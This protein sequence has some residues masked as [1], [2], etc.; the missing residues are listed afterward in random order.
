MTRHGTFWIGWTTTDDGT[1]RNIFTAIPG[2]TSMGTA[3]GVDFTR[4]NVT[5]NGTLSA[6]LNPDSEDDETSFAHRPDKLGMHGWFDGAADSRHTFNEFVADFR[7]VCSIDSHKGSVVTD[8][9]QK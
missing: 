2:G 5:G 7:F 4:T 1:E 3:G 9:D 8:A 6:A